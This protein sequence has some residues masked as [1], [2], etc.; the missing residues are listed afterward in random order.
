MNVEMYLGR[1]WVADGF[2]C[3]ELLRE[4]YANELGVCVPSVGVNADDVQ[5]VGH[6][7]AHHAVKS[8]FVRI[9]TP[10]HLCAVTM[11]HLHSKH[12]SHCGV[13]V[14][15]PEGGRI[16]HNWRGAGVL[17]DMPSRLHWLQLEVTGYYVYI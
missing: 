2:N 3:W 10:Q 7:F 4:V 16:L 6:A 14:L 9:D 11:R 17:L 13:F 12:D 8:S 15:L 5:K 1:P